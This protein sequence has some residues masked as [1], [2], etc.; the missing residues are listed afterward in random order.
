MIVTK[1]QGG[2]G[3]QI[4]QWA[5]CKKLSIKYNLPLYLDLSFYNNQN[6]CTKREFE[7]N[8]FSNLKYNI[9]DKSFDNISFNKII[10]TFYHNEF[11]YN[12]YNNYYIDGYWQT[13]KY[14]K[15]VENI[16]RA[17]LSPN[18]EKLAKLKLTPLIDTNTISMHIRRTDYI[19]LNDYHPIQLISYYEEALNIIGKYDYIFIFSDDIKWCKENLHFN[20]MIFMENF[21][22]IDD[23]YIM[24]MCKH[25]IIANS[26]FSWWGAWL[27]NNPN[28][29]VIT[30]LNWFGTMANLNDNDIIPN[31]WIRI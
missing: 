13:E 28:K 21:D 11:D 1:I 15:E 10:D 5:Y 20:N 6:G 12:V 7:L 19:A 25:N 31:T 4:F 27:N 22:D 24:S 26:S 23:L 2:L 29:K 14:F 3:N 18:E 9:L 17:E 8:K 30:P 16:I